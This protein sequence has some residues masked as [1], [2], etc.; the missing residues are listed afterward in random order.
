M[1]NVL[2]IDDE[3]EIV[4]L[5]EVYLVNEGYKVFKAYNG[6]DGINIINEEKIH[7][8]VLD[9]MMPG[10]DGFQV[11][12]KIRKDYNIPIIMLSAKSQDVDKIQGLSTGADDYMIK[13]FN[14]M[15]LIARV[16]SQIRRYVFLNEKSNKSNDIDIIEF[17]D[18]TINKKN[19]KVL[20]LGKELKLTPIEYEIL[21]LL[22]N[23]LG[24]VFSAE[25]IFKEVWKEKYFEGNN[26]VMVHIWR[27]RE[28]IEE[29][30]KE[31]KIIETVWGVG[32]KIEE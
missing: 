22:A 11:C 7:V 25:D 21:L 13:P 23:N 14:P 8:V 30:P 16:K 31:P 20:F 12:M 4:E 28:K 2:I 6:S 27:L 19:H 17:K 32:Y 10:I 1:F 15:E 18:I 24:T 5:I 9:V 3:V 29:N 26:T